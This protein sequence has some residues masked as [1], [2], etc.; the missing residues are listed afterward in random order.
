MTT[1]AMLIQ[2]V[3]TAARV[4]VPTFGVAA[5]LVMSRQPELWAATE[6]GGTINWLPFAAIGCLIATLIGLVRMRV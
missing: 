1:I 6:P 2:H 3:L 5:I 4:M